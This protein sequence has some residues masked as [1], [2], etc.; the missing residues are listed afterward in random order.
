MQ[1]AHS[2]TLQAASA[3]NAIF[4]SSGSVQNRSPV[5]SS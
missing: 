5:D 2:E 1:A 4:I 3:E